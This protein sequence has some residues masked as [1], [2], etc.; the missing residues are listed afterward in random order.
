MHNTGSDNHISNQ[1]SS[2]QHDKYPASSIAPS[3]KQMIDRVQQAKKNRS[4]FEA[5]RKGDVEQVRQLI[6]EGADIDAKWG[7]TSTTEKEDI[8][9][10]TPL[11]YAVDANNMDLVKLLVEAG[12]D[13]NA[14]SWPPL[15]GA[16]D[17][18]NTA[19]AEYLIDHGANINV[20][21]LGGSLEGWGP[22]QET[23]VINN[24]IEMAKLLIAKGGDINSVIYPAL[25]SAIYEKRKDLSELLIQRGADVNTIDKWGHS[26]LYFALVRYDDLDIMNIL[27]ANGA[28][29]DIKHPGGETV[30]MS[31]ATA[32]RTEA[33]KLLLEADANVNAKNDRGQTALHV[34]LDI[35]NSDYHKYRLSKDTI[36]LL[37]AS[38]ADVN[39]KDKEGRTPL[40]LAA[41][42]AD[43]DIVKLLLDKGAK[44]NAKDDESGFTPLHYAARFGKKNV[45]ELLIA[46]GADIN[47][48][49]KQ[50]HTPLYI[51]V[52]HDYKVAELFMDKGADSTIE[53]ESGPTLL[54]LAQQRKQL[55]STAPDLIFD[56]DP[57]SA[58]GNKIACGDVDADGYDDI[59]IVATSYKN[60]RGGVYLFYG[61]PNMDATPDLI[62][63]GQN[64]GD[65][66]GNGI[67]C[68]DID[69]DGYEDIVI[70]AS[71]FNEKRGCVYLYWGSDRNSM[72]AKPDKIFVGDVEKLAQ[73][74]A[75]H[76]AASSCRL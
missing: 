12:A 60:R 56:G 43:R 53:T 14:G 72:D 36:E 35:R 46:K 11:Y 63:E 8:A 68:G 26:P 75:H 19:I 40:H 32:G 20:Y 2:M 30:L 25:N 67:A 28:E 57:N 61:G 76:P 38:G 24:S 3:T 6:A 52:N 74:G 5:I 55:E 51:A 47:A 64:E 18:N 71:Y 34:P 44:V 48:K 39:L 27:I 41:E 45:A 70:A 22:L 9:D 37:L 66:F 65:F 58:F 31:A 13:V 10:D 16:V 50:D 69:S 29:V 59:L 17:K 4:L 33:V 49:D 21:P 1:N 23:A 7:D 42:S 54:E 15:F 62:L 73:L